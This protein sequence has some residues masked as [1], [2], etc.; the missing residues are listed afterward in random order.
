MTQIDA[1]E[2]ADRAAMP[3]AHKNARLATSNWRSCCVLDAC[4]VEWPLRLLS[5]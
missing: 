2:Q 4:G 5:I 3:I 1:E